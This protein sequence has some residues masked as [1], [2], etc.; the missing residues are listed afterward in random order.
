MTSFIDI[1]IH[2]RCLILI[3]AIIIDAIWGEPEWLWHRVPH[4]VVLF[5]RLIN[6][7]TRIGNQSRFQGHRRRLNG[8]V[9]VGVCGS[10]ATFTGYALAQFGFIAELVCLSIL[11]AGHSLHQHVKAVADAFDISVKAARQSVGQIVGRNTATMTASQ[12]SRAAIE[13]DAENLSDGVIAPAFWFL[14][15]GL[16]GLFLYKMINTADS[17]IGYKNA[18]FYA[19]GWATAKLDDLANFFPARLTGWLIVIAC[20]GANG[21][22]IAALKT[23]L[24][25]AVKHA[26]PNAGWP[27]AAIAGG[28]G[29]WLGGSRKYGN[30]LVI[31]NKFNP[32]GREVKVTDIYAAL[33]IIKR[34]QWILGFLLC[35]A[36]STLLYDIF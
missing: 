6:T 8:I 4:P 7:A 21:G 9:A 13:T 36:L 5:G 18:Q 31:A 2:Q 20:I 15:F 26:S 29:I 14:I 30:R 33:K 10:F 27:E 25:D 17:M 3:L 35:M 1:G 11:L 32:S 12:I 23:M 19:F 34:A 28:L 22:A 16:P 24:S